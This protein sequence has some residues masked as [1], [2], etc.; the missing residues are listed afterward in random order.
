MT[1]TRSLPALAR[2][3]FGLAALAW[4][5]LAAAA[6]DIDAL[7]DFSRPAVSEQ[8]FRD[9]LAQADGDHALVLR[10]QIARTLGLRGRFEEGHRELDEVDRQLAAAGPEPRARARLERGRMLR[11][12]GHPGPARPLFVQ[13]YETAEANGLAALAADALHM[14]ALVEPTLEGQLAWNQRTID[15]ARAASDPK[16]RR[17]EAPALNNMGSSLRSVGRLEPSLAVF[18]QALAAYE[19]LGRPDRIAFARWQVAHV[20]RLL[21]RLDESLALLLALEREAASRGVPDP[22]VLQELALLHDALGN[23]RQAARYRALRHRAQS[24]TKEPA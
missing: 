18:R 7:W 5:G 17:W 2:A 10:T 23:D 20:L 24:A 21:G 22:D 19:R 1:S 3:T 15:H 16:A 12:S 4:A 14:V 11:S 8:R 13:A 6:A 9:A